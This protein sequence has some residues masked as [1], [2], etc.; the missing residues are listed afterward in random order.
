M[1]GNLYH[2]YSDPDLIAA[3]VL[4]PFLHGQCLS[5][6]NPMLTLIGLCNMLKRLHL[7]VFKEAVNSS[8]QSAFMDYY[9]EHEEFDPVFMALDEWKTMAKD[10]VSLMSPESF[11]SINVI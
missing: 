4:N 7:R 11:F 5:R 3:I 6:A 8:F 2:I 1:L 10:K 9:N